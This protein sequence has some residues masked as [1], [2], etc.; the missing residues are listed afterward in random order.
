M[1]SYISKTLVVTVKALVKTEDLAKFYTI[2][3]EIFTDPLVPP[4]FVQYMASS[5]I[6]ASH[7]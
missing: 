6:L 1:P 4:S 2:W 5:W 7:M 3:D